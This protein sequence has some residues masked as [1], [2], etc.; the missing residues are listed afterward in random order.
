MKAERINELKRCYQPFEMITT[1]I[2][3]YQRSAALKASPSLNFK[4]ERKEK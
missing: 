3:G 2:L 4:D 1:T